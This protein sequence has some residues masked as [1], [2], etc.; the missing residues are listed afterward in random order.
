MKAR[1][2]SKVVRVLKPVH[3]SRRCLQHT[4]TRGLSLSIGLKDKDGGQRGT[5][6]YIQAERYFQNILDEHETGV[7]LAGTGQFMLKDNSRLVVLNF[8]ENFLTDE[9]AVYLNPKHLLDVG[10]HLKHRLKLYQ[11]VC[12]NTNLHVY[13]GVLDFVNNSY[14]RFGFTLNPY[15]MFSID[16]RL[17]ILKGTDLHTSIRGRQEVVDVED[18]EHIG[19]WV[20]KFPYNQRRLVLGLKNDTGLGCRSLVLVDDLNND[21]SGDLFRLA[22]DTEWMLKAAA[23]L[24]A[25]IRSQGNKDLYMK[26]SAP[27]QPKN[28]VWV[29]I[30]QKKWMKMAKKSARDWTEGDDS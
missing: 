30:Q 29:A 22:V 5:K 13:P 24:C 27:L 8:E 15:S 19:V 4:H 28:N 21:T 17:C 25:K 16:E 11:C 3:H 7:M 18:V 9:E 12:A 23:V 14:W 1:H 26:V 6:T 10:C 20:S 2:I